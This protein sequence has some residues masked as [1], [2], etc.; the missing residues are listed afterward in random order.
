MDNALFLNSPGT[1]SLLPYRY[2]DRTLRCAVRTMC[3]WPKLEED[4]LFSLMLDPR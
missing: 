3:T 1:C 2:P 4:E